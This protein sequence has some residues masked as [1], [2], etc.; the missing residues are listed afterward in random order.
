MLPLLGLLFFHQKL[1]WAFKKQPK[2]QYF[3]Q[4]GHPDSKG[5]FRP[6]FAWSV[7]DEDRKFVKFDT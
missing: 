7:S 6:Y 5:G 4:S 2:W 3:P 1:T